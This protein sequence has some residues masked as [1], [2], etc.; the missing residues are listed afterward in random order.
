MRKHWGHALT[1]IR[2]VVQ[3]LRGRTDGDVARL[4]L[5]RPDNLFQ[6]HR[7]TRLDRYPRIFRFVRD[8]IGEQSAARILSFGCAT[9]EEVLSLRKYFPRAVIRGIDIN[10][11]NIQICREQV[12]HADPGLSFVLAGSVEAEATASY[13]L[14]LAMA[15]FRHGDLG[16]VP[17]RCDH[18]IRF[19]DFERTISDLARILRPGG[20]LAIRFANF[21]FSD[22][23]VAAEFETVLTL[24]DGPGLGVTPLY[25]RDNTLLDGMVY[26]DVVFRKRMIATNN[27]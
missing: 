16:V 22:T 27:V 21:R 5:A 20:L 24:E 2:L 13:D 26:G 10:P 14:V 17:A 12:G 23:R 25:G 19:A 15:V 4:R 18:L 7:K 8:T 1:N 11:A 6:P 9:G 3:W